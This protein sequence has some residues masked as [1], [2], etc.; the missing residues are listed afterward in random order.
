[1]RSNFQAWL[2]EADMPQRD[3]QGNWFDA[4]DGLHYDPTIDYC[5]LSRPRRAV[6]ESGS[7][8]RRPLAHR[9]S[10]QAGC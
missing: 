5:K 9:P 8:G 2:D 6:S 7:G 10:G 4:E 1:M 3:A